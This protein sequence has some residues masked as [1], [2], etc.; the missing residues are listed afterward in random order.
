VVQFF[1]ALDQLVFRLFSLA[2]IENCTLSPFLDM[3]AGRYQPTADNSGDPEQKQTVPLPRGRKK[4]CSQKS[5][6]FIGDYLY[7][8]VRNRR[9]VGI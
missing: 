3:W 6:D 8:M 7:N 1:F 2:C 5:H 4:K 9:Q